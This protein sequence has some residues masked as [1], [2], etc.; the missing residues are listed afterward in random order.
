MRRIK[1]S[2]LSI[3]TIFLFSFLSITVLSITLFYFITIN[4]IS[5]NLDKT[6]YNELKIHSGVIQEDFNALNASLAR[7]ATDYGFWDEAFLKA[8]ENDRDFFRKNYIEWLPEN[9]DID[10]ILVLNSN[11]DVLASYGPAPES[12]QGDRW[13]ELAVNNTLNNRY[14]SIDELF[15]GGLV[16]VGESL[17]SIGVSP[18]VS[19]DLLSPPDG[20]IM[21]GK[22]IDGQFM[23][24]LGDRY[25]YK[26]SILLGGGAIFGELPKESISQY[27]KEGSQSTKRIDA[28]SLISSPLKD[29]L[30]NKV[31]DLIIGSSNNQYSQLYSSVN[32]SIGIGSFI[33]LATIIVLSL[34]LSKVITSPLRKME[35]EINR[36]MKSR[37]LEPIE[38][39]ESTSEIK[40]VTNA[41]NSLIETI[42]S[43]EEDIETKDRF[44]ALISHEFKTPITIINAAI[45]A[46]NII[47]KNEITP[48]I[49]SYLNKINRNS[50]RQLRLVDNLLDITR[51]KDGQIKISEKSIDIVF[52]TKEIVDSVRIYALQKNIPLSFRSDPD[53]MILLL[54]EQKYERILLNLISNAIKFTPPGKSIEVCL[55]TEY[56]WLKVEVADTG[57]GIPK[58]KQDMIFERFGQVDS[59]L[60]RQAEGTGIG[61]YLVKSFVTLLGGEITLVSEEGLGSSFTVYLPL[62]TDLSQT[63]GE[64]PLDDKVEYATSLEF[65]DII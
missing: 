48:K 65:S 28:Y 19:Q 38:D 51:I 62:K 59:S 24:D 41:L 35:N 21:V 20:V 45:Q 64:N 5:D 22:Q 63:D 1:L 15:K 14:Q 60:S 7:L 49:A 54:D 16:Q 50:L 46:M 57:I 2:D 9:L 25:N 42:H 55:S 30:N 13:I 17:Y 47:C 34:L 61:L 43:R 18:I 39:I 56:E 31:A 37:R 12:I 33:V 8:K 29:S 11:E 32:N 52:H 27:L 26:V 6:E 53:K 44:I 40:T 58:E 4:S 23:K 3:R 36:M 10:L